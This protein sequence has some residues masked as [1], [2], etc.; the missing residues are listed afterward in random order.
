MFV[1]AYV[2]TVRNGKEARYVDQCVWPGR[3]FFVIVVIV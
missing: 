2:G 1:F 3:V